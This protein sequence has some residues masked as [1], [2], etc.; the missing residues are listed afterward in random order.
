MENH[1]V[2][3]EALLKNV[4]DRFQRTIYTEFA[5]ENAM[6]IA[7]TRRILVTAED[8]GRINIVWVDNSV[9]NTP[10]VFTSWALVYMYMLNIDDMEA[11][12]IK[13]NLSPA[14][15]WCIY[16]TFVRGTGLMMS[17]NDFIHRS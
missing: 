5:K 16:N 10:I 13:Q 9:W 15:L 6:K 11:E 8:N 1:Y 17:F 4:G 14:D 2:L 7:V 12:G 3:I